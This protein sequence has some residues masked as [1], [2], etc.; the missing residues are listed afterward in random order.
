MVYI[1]TGGSKGIGK[2][3]V[4]ILRGQGHTV[5]DVSRSGDIK[6]DMGK[7]EDRQRAIAQIHEMFPDGIDGV[8]TNAGIPGFIRGQ[9]AADVI[10]V[11]YFG[12]V[13]MLN[14]LFDLLEKKKG[15]AVV[16]TS[17]SI[18][19][20]PRGR[21]NVDDLLINCE[22]E[23]RL[24]EFVTELEKE[25]KAM[26]MY[27]STKL[28]LTKWVKRTASSWAVRGVILN[29]VAPGGVNTDIIPNMK[30]DERFETVTMANPMPT[31]YADRDLMTP[32]SIAETLAFMVSP[33]ARGNCGTIVYCDGGSSAIVNSEVYL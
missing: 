2:C 31:V 27:P 5:V 22:D 29:A 12:T 24:R 9:T 21:Y 20:Y 18:A 4:D 14:G 26:A 3:T 23:P 16:T 30:T 6:A 8:I 19:Y 25:G 28:A 13:D 7:P 17:A 15:N 32:E 33:K 10:S 1:I 11:N